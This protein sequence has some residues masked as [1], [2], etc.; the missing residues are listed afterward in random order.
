M[1]E[2]ETWH[3][4]C[5]HKEGVGGRVWLEKTDRGVHGGVF[6]VGA[7]GRTKSKEIKCV[8]NSH[9]VR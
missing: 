8:L 1:S 6:A 5:A 3:R 7:G 4:H 9:H 2:D